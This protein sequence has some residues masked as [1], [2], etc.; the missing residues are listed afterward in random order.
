MTGSGAAEDALG[1]LAQA[2]PEGSF[3]QPD[4]PAVKP[5]GRRSEGIVVPSDVSYAAM[6]G[7]FLPKSL[8]GAQ[9][10]GRMVSLGY[11][12]NA[13]RVQGGAYGVGMGVRGSGT[14]GFYSFRDPTAA[15]TLDCYR[16]SGDFLRETKDMD[17]TG[18]ILGALAESDPL[19]TPRMKG[20]TADNYYW[21]G[22]SYEDLCRDRQEMLAAGPEDLTALA[23]ELDRLAKD[24]SVCVL[25]SRKQLESCQGLDEV[26]VL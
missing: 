19:L 12:W 16:A 7:V 25:G 9:V 11:L 18:M 15:R 8:G 3:A 6:G 20:K 1:H 4:G 22:V 14:V 21:R 17:L 26:T 10:A 23:E 13:V 2:L 5:W 24:A